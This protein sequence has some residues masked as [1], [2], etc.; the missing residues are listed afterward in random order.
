MNLASR[1]LNFGLQF[2]TLR[3]LFITAF[4]LAFTCC[5]S[6]VMAADLDDARALFDK[7]DYDACIENDQGRSGTRHLA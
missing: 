1:A 7:G 4:F 2:A 6:P 3:L 5:L